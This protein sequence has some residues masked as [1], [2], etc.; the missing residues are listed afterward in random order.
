MSLEIDP[1]E[2]TDLIENPGQL[3]EKAFDTLLEAFEGDDLG[4]IL[5]GTLEVLDA[6][7]GE[8]LQ[9]LEKFFDQAIELIGESGILEELAGNLGKLGEAL[10]DGI[11]RI[12]ELPINDILRIGALALLAVNDIPI[13]P[14]LVRVLT[15][16]IPAFEGPAVLEARE[17]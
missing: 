1:L 4:D 10:L 6:M 8:G 17:A 5:G 7:L 15:D 16:M 14:E 11:E 13:D 12:M 2:L 9:V 3:L